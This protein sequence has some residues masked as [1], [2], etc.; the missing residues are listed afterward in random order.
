MIHATYSVCRQRS[1]RIHGLGLCGSFSSVT[2][3]DG[4]ATEKEFVKRKVALTLGFVGSKY[5][6]LQYN[7]AVPLPTIEHDVLSALYKAGYISGL[8]AMNPVK[9]KLSRASRTDKG[10][11]AVRTVLSLKLLVPRAKLTQ[12]G[13]GSNSY[14]PFLPAEVNKFLPMD[15]R[16]FGAVTTNSSFAAKTVCWFCR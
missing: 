4:G 10:V 1:L 8:N 12:V 3:P 16:I 7:P 6:G 9:V 13:H 5:Y 11:H 15:I 14:L 2:A